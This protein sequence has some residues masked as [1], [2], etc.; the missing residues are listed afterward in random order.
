M[1]KE[2]NT[3]ICLSN[4]DNH[5]NVNLAGQ[6]LIQDLSIFKYNYFLT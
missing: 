4:I 2:L 6:L 3:G 5:M 1:G